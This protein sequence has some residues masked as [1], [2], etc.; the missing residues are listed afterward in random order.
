MHTSLASRNSA[1]EL[2]RLIA[3]LMI[4]GYHWV[5]VSD[6]TWIGNQ[7]LGFTKFFYQV[8]I[9]GGGWVGNFIFFAISTW[10]L[11]DRAADLKSSFRRIWIL[12]REMLFW[13][14]TLLI[15]SLAL[16][17]RDKGHITSVVIIKSFLPLLTGL[18]W[19]PTSYALFLLFMPFL[20][21]GMKQLG[22][23]NHRSLAIIVFFIWGILAMVPKVSLS[24]D[25]SSASVFVF[26][27]WFILLSYWKWYRLAMSTRTCWCLIVAGLAIELLY[28]GAGNVRYMLSGKGLSL[29]YF[30]FDHWKLPSMMI[31]MGLFSL[32]LKVSWH[33]R[34]INWMAASAFGIYLIHFH[35]VIFAYWTTRVFNIRDVYQYSHAILK[36]V[37]IVV[38]VCAVCL[39]LDMIRHVIF[40][41]VVDRHRG[42]WFDLL[43]DK[44]AALADSLI[45]RFD[46][47]KPGDMDDSEGASGCGCSGAVGPSDRME[48]AHG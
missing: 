44:M 25:L 43:W 16:A 15:V 27:Y 28:W 33:S 2:L 48:A 17:H 5:Y 8:I 12:E 3:M 9:A 47:T 37:G 7:S 31:G 38:L 40:M 30:I 4:V 26:I 10:F 29:Q 21:S 14:V 34:I 35:P 46:T 23:R 18:W 41:L 32:A 13:S 1:V 45:E 20:V 6:A 42:R 24:P 11:L 36:G 39:M 22:Q 19:Y